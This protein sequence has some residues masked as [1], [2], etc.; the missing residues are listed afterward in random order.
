MIKLFVSDLD[1]TMVISGKYPSEKNIA[2]VQKMINAGITVT[3]ASGRM[4]RAALPIAKKLGVN[5]PI[6]TYNGALIKTV[7]GEII[8]S[9][10]FPKDLRIFSLSFGT[11][12]TGS[13]GLRFGNN[14]F[15]LSSIPIETLPSNFV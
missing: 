7:N 10:Y 13:G 14:F 4:Y 5:V 3:I 1:G 11:L 9:E 2:A 6:I 15:I 12:L 8:H